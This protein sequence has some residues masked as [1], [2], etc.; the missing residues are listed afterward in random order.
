[1]CTSALQGSFS[2]RM[3]L[4]CSCCP[5]AAW[6]AHVLVVLSYR[7]GGA[8]TQQHAPRPAHG[9]VWYGGTPPPLPFHCLSLRLGDNLLVLGGDDGSGVKNDVSCFPLRR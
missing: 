5:S 9:M 3:A 2:Q 7:L 4:A 6:T 8:C 1:M